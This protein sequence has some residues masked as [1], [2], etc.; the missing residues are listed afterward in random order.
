MSTPTNEQN[1]HSPLRCAIESRN[2][3][4]I[5]SITTTNSVDFANDY[6]REELLRAVFINVDD[7]E[8]IFT[9]LATIFRTAVNCPM[10]CK[11]SSII[12]RIASFGSLPLLQ[13]YIDFITPHCNNDNNAA[14]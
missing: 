10:V 9:I 13:R 4:L 8:A 12:G 7:E 1:P 11:N 5:E 14:E 6:D 3:E 2:L